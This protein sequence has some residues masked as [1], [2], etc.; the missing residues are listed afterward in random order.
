MKPAGTASSTGKKAYWFTPGLKI[1]AAGAE[2]KVHRVP[3]P[4][5][6]GLEALPLLARL[7]PEVACLWLYIT[8]CPVV[9][10]WGAKKHRGMAV[11]RQ[12]NATLVKLHSKQVP[13]V[14]RGLR[15]LKCCM[16]CGACSGCV[17]AAHLLKQDHSVH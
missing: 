14:Q 11:A 12:F 7:V 3:S 17:C 5:F 10:A 8:D 15:Y 2:L 9:R 4:C 13:A 6:G 1:L 16:V